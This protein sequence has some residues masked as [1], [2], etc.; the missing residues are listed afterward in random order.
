MKSDERWFRL[1]GTVTYAT[2]WFVQAGTRE[3]AEAVYW[4]IEE[5]ATGDILEERLLEIQNCE[6][7]L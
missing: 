1:R 7:P 6:P 5:P 2:E 4:G 3:E